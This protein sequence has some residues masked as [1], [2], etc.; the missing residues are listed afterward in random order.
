MKFFKQNFGEKSKQHTLK[1]D[2][3][4]ENWKICVAGKSADYEDDAY[5]LRFQ[6]K[7]RYLTNL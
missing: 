5:G 7:Q 2:F 1:E 4:V 3:M 6:T